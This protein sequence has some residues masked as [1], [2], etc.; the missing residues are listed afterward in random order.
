MIERNFSKAIEFELTRRQFLRWA[1]IGVAGALLPKK[2]LV[3]RVYA[4]SRD[5]LYPLLGRVTQAAVL[6]HKKADPES[7][8]LM[9]MDMDSVWQITGKVMGEN[10]VSSNKIWYELDGKGFAHSRRIQPVKQIY[11]QPRMILPPEGC[12]GEVTIPFVDA[13]KNIHRDSEI[14]YRLYYAATF[15]VLKS[16]LDERDQIWYEL[17]DDRTYQVFYV[18]ADYIRL[19]PDSEL[20]PIFPEVPPE[21]KKIVVDLG[22][23]LLTAYQDENM[24]YTSRISSGVRFHEGGFATPKGNYHI[25]RKR[26]CRHMAAAPSEFGSGF[27][28]PGVPWVSY[29]TSD[30]IALHGAYWHNDFGVPYSHGCI[31]MTPNSAKWIYRWSTPSVPPD[32]YYFAETNGTRIIIQ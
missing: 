22:K 9:E 5:N 26:P 12:L 28:L 10:D 21:S 32:R 31:N 2:R 24:V 15:W 27:D 19:V 13:T 4:R 1:G 6:L 25:T 17:L 18:P 7:D 29:F 8:V 23:Q 11:N 30:G 20:T 14:V 16:K 3:G